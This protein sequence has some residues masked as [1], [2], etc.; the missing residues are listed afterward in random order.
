MP[1]D[2]GPWPDGAVPPIHYA[3]ARGARLAYQDF[4]SG[5]KTLVGIPPLAQNIEAA[6]EQPLIRTMLTRIGS[7]CR[8]VPFDKRGSGGSDRQSVMP[9]IDERVDDLRAI[10]DAAGIQ[11]SFLYGA[12]EGGPMCLLFAATYPD[13]VEGLILQ[14][15]GAHI[16]DPELD[17]EGLTKRR[18]LHQLLLDR[19]GTPDSMMVDAFAPSLSGDDDFRRWHE[20]YERIAAD[21]GSLA[22]S[23]EL[24]FGIDVRSVLPRIE[25]PTLVLHKRDDPIVPI[26]YGRTV[27]EALPNAELIEFDGNDH[28]PFVELSWLEHLEQFVTGTVTE[29]STSAMARTAVHI[30]TLGR[31]AVSVGGE[32]VATAEWGSRLARQLCKRLVAA[33]GWPLTR[34]QLFDLLW[35]DEGDT[36]RLGAR[37]SV[38]LSTIRRILGGGIIADRQTIAIDL[39]EISTDLEELHSAGDDAAVSVAYTGDFLPED[40]YDDWTTPVREEAAALFVGAARRLVAASTSADDH[41]QAAALSRRMIEIDPYDDVAHR[42]LVVALCASDHGA[43]ARRAHAQW[44]AALSE[45]G[46]AAPPFDEVN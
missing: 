31:F 12:S 32:E 10:M 34:E 33:R 19:W 43:A 46:A 35:P 27:A 4:G 28:Y 18:A 36:R 23:L 30:Q 45:I 25:A 42:S 9:G 21:R 5:P 44:A 40:R 38:L 39:G 41:E 29:G 22:Q 14:G 6:W 2:P 17:E 15:S 20:R 16:E 24:S 37:L 13:R 26:A 11:R 8:F 7:F 3:E 1:T